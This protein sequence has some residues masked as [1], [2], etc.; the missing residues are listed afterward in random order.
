M[1]DKIIHVEVVGKDG[2][3]LQR[4]YSDVFGWELDTDNPGG[5]GMLRQGELT[6]GIGPTPDGVAGH[7][8]FY[9]HADD[10][11]AHPGRARS[12]AGG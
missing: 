6:A 10:P 3:A 4:F 11:A 1:A 9:V 5:Y 8:T 12:S 2:A 7:V